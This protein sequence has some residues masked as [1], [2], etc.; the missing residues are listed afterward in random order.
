MNDV[1]TD[2][3]QI[4]EQILVYDVSDEALEAATANGNA[5]L[6]NGSYCFT[7]AVSGRAG[8]G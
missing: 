1:N 3:D 6:L 5:T 4:D 2:R 8:T 7:C